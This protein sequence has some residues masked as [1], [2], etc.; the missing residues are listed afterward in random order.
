ML[1]WNDGAAVER[2]L[3]A[4][5]DEVAAVIMEPILCNTCVIV[6]PPGYLEKRPR[7]GHASRRG[8]RSSTR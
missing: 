5:G 7:A 2:L 1:P 8:A 4:H 3:A 6:A